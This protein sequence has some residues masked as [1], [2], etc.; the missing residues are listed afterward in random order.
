MSKTLDAIRYCLD[1]L[2]VTPKELFSLIESSNGYDGP[3]YSRWLAN[4]VIKIAESEDILYSQLLAKWFNIIQNI[5]DEY[6]DSSIKSCYDLKIK[7][8]IKNKYVYTIGFSDDN[9]FGTPIDEIDWNTGVDLPFNPNFIN[10]LPNE[11]SSA[12]HNDEG[13]TILVK[14]NPK[15]SFKK[16]SD[17]AIDAKMNG[18]SL[19]SF[20][21]MLMYRMCSFIRALDDEA[22]NFKFVF[23]TDTKFLYN[24]DNVDII[25]YFLSYFDYEGFVVNSKD[26]YEG[27]FTSE[28]YAICACKM[29]NDGK[30]KN[31]FLLEKYSDLDGDIVSDGI[32][33]RY[34]K[35]SN[36]LETLMSNNV[37]SDKVPCISRDNKVIGTT[38]GNKKA[39]GYLCKGVVDRN[40]IVSN[41]PIKDTEY[42]DIN[43]K[44]LLNIIAYYGVIMSMSGMGMFSDISDIIDGH[45]DFIIL[46]SNCIPL[47]L[48]DVNSMFCEIGDV[49]N[50]NGKVL[51]LYNNFG[52]NS[53]LVQSL[54]ERFS[55]YFSFE[56]KELM[57]V[58]ND[59]LK[60]YSGDYIGLTFNDIRS[61]LNNTDLNKNYILA[62]SRCKEF[63]KSLY[64]SMEV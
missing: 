54:L 44:N 34:S 8:F 51:H 19:K 60:S 49:T 41:F 50:K 47:F 46:A 2:G 52:I 38:V 23:I 53:D 12:L 59:I 26:L 29:Y 48:F 36:M 18:I 22:Y 63:V 33:R 16:N 43:D 39:N 11:L 7:E 57:S 25:K 24:A 20:D 5:I 61:S 64:S 45:P 30:S 37:Y 17:I 35:G 4:E 55:I 42:V 40:A 15:A 14:F 3:E 28:E 58:C 6:S 9:G 31:G 1:T 27:S 13:V 10:S 21:S 32:L 62:M 56:A